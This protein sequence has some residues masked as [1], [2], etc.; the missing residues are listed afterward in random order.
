MRRMV[1]RRLPRDQSKEIESHDPQQCHR[2]DS[3]LTTSPTSRERN[4]GKEE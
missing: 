4:E 1:E 3:I 2:Y